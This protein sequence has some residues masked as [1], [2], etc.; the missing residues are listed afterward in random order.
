MTKMDKP[1]ITFETERSYAR[2][3]KE[4]KEK[5]LSVSVNDGSQE[6]NYDDHDVK[7]AKD[8]RNRIHA[9]ALER[10][11]QIFPDVTSV[12]DRYSAGEYFQQIWDYP[13]AWYTI[14]AIPEKAG[15]REALIDTI[16]RDT[17]RNHR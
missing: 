16:V 9:E 17:I 7:D 14:V 3:V 5:T 2:S 15:S 10:V 4:D 1:M 12:V 11:Q 13:G 8:F 6:I